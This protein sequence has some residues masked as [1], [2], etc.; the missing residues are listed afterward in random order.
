MT[1]YNRRQTRFALLLIG[2]IAVILIYNLWNSIALT[3][4]NPF[5]EFADQKDQ[6]L[7]STTLYLLL[8]GAVEARMHGIFFS[9]IFSTA[10]YIKMRPLKDSWLYRSSKKKILWDTT[11]AAINMSL[12]LSSVMVIITILFTTL[13]L[14]EALAFPQR[15][16]FYF[17]AQLL[18]VFLFYLTLAQIFQTFYGLF[19][20]FGKAIIAS[21]LL[22]IFNYF[23]PITLHLTYWEPANALGA[24]GI[25]IFH[26]A[27]Y[28]YDFV[29]TSEMLSILVTQSLYLIVLILVLEV[30]KR[31]LFL[32]K[33][34]ILNA[35]EK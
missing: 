31:L 23:A 33:D 32:R 12:I 2:L 30:M 35:K 13:F 7:G 10:L 25:N 19:L 1:T 4:F 3:A 6:F 34:F 20:S 11:R 27:V 15:M 14:P 26:E 29:V 8:G 24:L 16:L 9:I 5:S 22:G 28:Y 21:S 18:I 17:S